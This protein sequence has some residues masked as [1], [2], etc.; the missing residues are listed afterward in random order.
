MYGLSADHV[1]ET[2][3]V[4][5]DGSVAEFAPKSPAELAQSEHQTGREAELHRQLLALVRDPHNLHTI[6]TATP[7]HWRRCGGYNL[8]RLTDGQGL[9]FRWPY[10]PRFNLAKVMCGSEGTLGVPG[11]DLL[12]TQLVCSRAAG[13]RRRVAQDLGWPAGGAGIGCRDLLHDRP[14]PASRQHCY[15]PAA[16]AARLSPRMNLSPIKRSSSICRRWYFS[17]SSVRK[18]WRVRGTGSSS[19]RPAL[20]P[21]VLCRCPIR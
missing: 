8:D 1:L 6:R 11:R 2:Q 3:V 12:R 16:A 9:S 20:V 10:D 13:A 14:G 4:L 21:R 5:A 18:P 19:I 17:N 7:P 15:G